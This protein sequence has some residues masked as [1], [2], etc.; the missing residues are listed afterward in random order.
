MKIRD[1]KLERGRDSDAEFGINFC[2]PDSLQANH[3]SILI[4]EN[5][6]RKS[7][8]LRDI[9]DITVSMA[10]SNRHERRTKTSEL[11]LWGGVNNENSLVSKVIAISGVASDR[12]PARITSRTHVSM[13]D[14]YDYI[15]PRTDNNLISRSHSINQVALSLLVRP[16]RVK[17]RHKELRHAFSILRVTSGIL[18]EFGPTKRGKGRILDADGRARLSKEKTNND[19]FK[20]VSILD[21]EKCLMIWIESTHH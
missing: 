3:F 9:V 5:G 21:V 10:A 20:G 6:T 13:V 17:S 7:R 2:P 11:S 14:Y 1:L 8:T 18:F 19:E 12:F 15:G 16:D 4:G